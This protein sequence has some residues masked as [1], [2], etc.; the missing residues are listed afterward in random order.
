M[1][2]IEGRR[3]RDGRRVGDGRKSLKWKE[4]SEMERR[5]R[6]GRKSMKWKE[7]SEMEGKSEMEGRVGK[8]QSCNRAVCKYLYSCGKRIHVAI[9]HLHHKYMYG[10]HRES[11]TPLT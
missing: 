9:V 10:T 1:S 5:V 2:E 8:S 11:P 3:V 6:D 4:E 7:E